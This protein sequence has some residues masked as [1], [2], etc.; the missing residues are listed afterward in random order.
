MDRPLIVFLIGLAGLFLGCASDDGGNGPQVIT[1]NEDAAI[2]DI[3]AAPEPDAQLPT[4]TFPGESVACAPNQNFQALVPI[5]SGGRTHPT[6]R[7]EQGS[8]FDPCN[9]R[10]ILFLQ[11]WDFRIGLLL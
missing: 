6:G 7:G 8:A 1:L 2:S 10:I 11:N 4:E 9:G 5:L 3:D